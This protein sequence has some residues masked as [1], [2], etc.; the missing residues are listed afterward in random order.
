MRVK[1]TKNIMNANGT[2]FKLTLSQIISVIIAFLTAVGTFLFLRD[3]L[4][5]NVI[6][7]IVFLELIVIAGPFVIRINDMS[8]LTLIIKMFKG[9]D[10][11]PYSSTKGVFDKDDFNIF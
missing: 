11:R 9:S 5:F 7:L 4:V 3:Y 10:K 6:M 1:V 2:I 8:L